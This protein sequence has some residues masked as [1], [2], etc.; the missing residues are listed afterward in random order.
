MTMRNMEFDTVIKIIT[1]N[2]T[3]ETLDLR[4]KALDDNQTIQ[5]ANVLSNNTSLKRL[6]LQDNQ[7]GRVGACEL[8]KA[9][10]VNKTLEELVLFSNQIGD[11]GA[12]ELARALSHYN[13]TL[14]RLCL[15]NNGLGNEGAKLL[16]RMLKRNTSLITLSLDFN[17]I[18]KEGAEF[19]A[20]ALE[21]NKTLRDLN[22]GTNREFGDDGAKIFAEVLKSN[23]FLRNFNLS[24]TGI[25]NTGAFAL[26]EMLR[27]NNVLQELNL[28]GN[29]ITSNGLM[30]FEK[31]LKDTMNSSLQMI[32]LTWNSFLSDTRTNDQK[33]LETIEKLVNKKRLEMEMQKQKREEE[34]RK[35]TQASKKTKQESEDSKEKSNRIMSSSTRTSVLSNTSELGIEEE[36]A[37]LKVQT[38]EK[39]RLLVGEADF[40]YTVALIK[41]IKDRLNRDIS[42]RIT[43]TEKES[44]D[45]LKKYYKETFSE[46]HKFLRD[47]TKTTIRFGVDATTI[48]TTFAGQRFRRIQ[49]NCPH[50]R[51]GNNYELMRKLIQDFFSN[52]AKLQLEGDRVQIALPKVHNSGPGNDR[53]RQAVIYGIYEAARN[54]GYVCIK[55]R[56]FG[57]ERYAGYEHCQT[58][59]QNEKQ[60]YGKVEKAG[61]LREY[62]FAKTNEI[63]RMILQFSPPRKYEGRNALPSLDTDADSSG[64]EDNDSDMERE[65]LRK[66]VAE[67]KA[68]RQNP[69]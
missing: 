11:N 69:S 35:K 1:E 62:I 39:N 40:G 43:A 13:T 58:V 53:W 21:T 37:K 56:M 68:K 22:L 6:L 60:D 20:K 36:M 8:A 42:K 66:K 15:G 44:K 63:P 12:C 47:E 27:R 38:K 25:S 2:S 26:A 19:L 3:G 52:A 32:D 33:L 29:Y 16:A 9:L 59:P 34:R 65:G 54:A 45:D 17:Q 7:I 28:R 5:L 31:A 67:M 46:N 41:K 10:K 23:A 61:N 24:E 48:A 4:T 49:F 14:R 50:N 64:Y 55:K 51:C 18:G 30:A 57:P